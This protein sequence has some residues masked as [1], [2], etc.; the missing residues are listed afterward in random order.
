MDYF[1]CPYFGTD[2]ECTDERSAHVAERHGELASSYWNRV[3]KAIHEPDQVWSSSHPGNAI[4]FFRWYDDMAK[5]VLAVVNSD[6]TG[7][8]WL[9]T[10]YVTRTIRGGELL[11]PLK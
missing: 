7:R 8:N 1:P 4:L 11:W 3:A 2:V 9:V 6:E 10:A 5:Y